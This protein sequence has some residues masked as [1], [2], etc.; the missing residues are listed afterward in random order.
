MIE[1]DPDNEKSPWRVWCVLPDLPDKPILTET[2][3]LGFALSESPISGRAHYVLERS[4]FG[5]RAAAIRSLVL[6]RTLPGVPNDAWV[7]VTILD[8]DQLDEPLPEPP[9]PWPPA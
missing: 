5:I 1:H 4:F 9:S 8:T 7:R 6:I 2:L 3:A